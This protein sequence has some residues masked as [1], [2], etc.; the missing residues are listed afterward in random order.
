MIKSYNGS[1]FKSQNTPKSIKLYFRTQLDI[2]K[3]RQK[4]DLRFAAAEVVVVVY[5]LVDILCR[6]QK[7][8]LPNTPVISRYVVLSVISYI[9]RIKIYFIEAL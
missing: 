7:Y 8:D 6:G 1:I 2:N 3:D 4:I 5:N 9:L